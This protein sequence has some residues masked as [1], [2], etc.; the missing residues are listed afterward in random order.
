MRSCACM[1]DR[2]ID[3]FRTVPPRTRVRAAMVLLLFSV[4]A[5]PLTSLTV[6]AG[7]PQGVLAISWITLIVD[8]SIV[9]ITTDIADPD[10]NEG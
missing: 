2:L 9:V 6:L 4:V 3:A 7:E 8:S 10:T 5:W 1:I